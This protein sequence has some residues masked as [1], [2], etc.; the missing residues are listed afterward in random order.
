MQ[1]TLRG[2]VLVLLSVL[3]GCPTSP[4]GGDCTEKVEAWI[5]ADSDGFGAGEPEQVCPDTSG[6]ADSA[7][8]CDDENPDVHPGVEEACNGLDDDCNGTPDN[9]L[10]AITFY[11][12]ADG[13]GFGVRFPAEVGCTSPE[14]SWARNDDDCDDTSAIVNPEGVEICNA[15]LDDNCNGLADDADPLVDATTVPVWFLDADADGYGDRNEDKARCLPLPGYVDNDADCN[16][17]R[18]EVNPDAT[19]IC[20]N[21]D[22]D[23]D[24]QTDDADNSLDPATQTSFYADVDGDGFG[25]GSL[26]ILACAAVPGLSSAN[27]ND[28]D[29]TRPGVHPG[30]FEQLCDAVDNDC[31][32]ASSDDPDL[33]GDTVSV[34]SGDCNDTNGSISPLAAEVPS[35]GVD[36][37]CNGLE[38]C[39]ADLDQDGARDVTWTEIGDRTCTAAGFAQVSAPIDCDD[40]DPNVDVEVGWFVDDDGDG[41][42]GGDPLV[43]QCLNPGGGL[44]HETEVLDCDDADPVHSPDTLEV[45]NDGIDQNCDEAVDCADTD[46]VGAP[47]CLAVCADLPLASP[48]PVLA[49]GTTVGRNNDTIPGCNAYSTANDVA[50]E[51]TPPANGLYTIDLVGSAYDTMLYVLDGCGGAELACND[52]FVGLQSQV[53]VQLFAGQPVIIVVDGFGANNGQYTLNIN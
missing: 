52:D 48:V 21:V 14:G 45:C 15:G 6:Y 28:C 42:G 27:P 10:D 16:D 7:L 29:D 2:P 39:Y 40:T 30:A 24:H 11:T 38:G 13:D 12:D 18:E 17:A 5:D 25:D 3:A 20:N 36:A 53:Q 44:V 22:D 31:D 46:C 43:F 1:P 23:C 19:E 37:N 50:Y 32:V 9:G 51:W 4:S 49:N 26:E 33:D 8:D 47:G 34:C 41:F 35:D